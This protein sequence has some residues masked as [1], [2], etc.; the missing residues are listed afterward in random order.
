MRSLSLLVL[1]GSGL[2]LSAL[3]LPGCVLESGLNPKRT[4]ATFDTGETGDV[5]IDTDTEPDDTDTDETAPPPDCDDEVFP[6]AA[7]A[8]LEECFSEGVEVGS[9][10]PVLEWTN[11][12]PGDTYTTPVVGQLTDDNGNGRIDDGD[13]PDVVVANTSGVLWAISGDGTTLWSAGNLGSEPMTAA[14][15]D[16]DGDGFPEVVGSG[17]SGTIA[18]HGENGATVWNAG[19]ASSPACGAVAIADLDADGAPEVILGNLILNGQTGSTRGTGAYGKGTGYS[20][21]GAATMGAAADIN[22]DG[23]LEVVVGNALYDADG[24]TIWTN[25]LPDG[26]VAVADFDGD[27]AGEIVVTWNGNVR[28]QDDDGSVIWTGNYVG[29]TSGPPTVADFDGDGEPEIGV[30]GNG[31]YKVIDADGTTLWSRPTQDFSSGF[32]GSSVFDFEGDGIAE[33]VYADENDV[34]V[35]DGPTGA[36]KLREPTHSSATCSEYPAVADVDGDGHAEIIYT[37]SAYSGTERGVRVIGDADNSWM[38]GRKVWNQHAYSI[39]NVEDD[40]TIPVV[41]DVNWDSYNN[42]RS[43]DITPGEGGYSGP[44]LFP[45]LHAVCADECESGNVTVWY[46]LGNQGFNDVE[47]AVQVEFWGD[48]DAGRVLLGTVS[49]TAD[50]VAGVRTPSESIEF[51]GVPSPLYDVIVTVDGGDDTGAGVVDEC[52]EDNNTASWGSAVCL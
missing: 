35:F 50:L 49:W 11:T 1:S 38:R 51:T 20:G 45:F 21:G 13:T 32:T 34:F 12:D 24:N 4:D 44:D 14:I 42:F 48:T 18:V 6:A 28:L 36:I 15:G 39:T 8:Q 2:L 10:T 37:S 26:F 41:P 29:G 19:A 30:A 47:D 17:Y 5:P 43:G 23:Y 27:P 16:L 40:A 9:F 46:S 33:V 25:G 31:Q 3:V 22:R 52:Y 7:V